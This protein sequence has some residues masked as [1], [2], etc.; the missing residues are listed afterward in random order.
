M[1][2]TICELLGAI[3]FAVCAAMVTVH[4]SAWLSWAVT[5]LVFFAA[6]WLMGWAV[7]HAYGPGFVGLTYWDD[8]DE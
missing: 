7:D 8:S 2:R 6:W 1:G 3:F 4:T 5:L